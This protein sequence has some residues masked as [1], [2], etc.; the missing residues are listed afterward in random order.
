MGLLVAGAAL[1]MLSRYR[2]RLL[3]AA[4]AL[5]PIV[6]VSLPED[7]QMRFLT[8]LD[9]SVGPANAQESAENRERYFWIALDLWRQ[10]PI[11]GHGPN[12]FRYLSGTGQPA[13]TL[14]GEVLSEVGLLG[15]GALVGLLVGVA[16]NTRE[17]ARSYSG[18]PWSK[19]PFLSWLSIAIC[20]AMTLLLLLGIGGHNLYRF[21]W[22]W[23]GAFLAI[24]VRCVQDGKVWGE[25]DPSVGVEVLDCYDEQ[26]EVELT[27]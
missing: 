26:F 22:L 8:I 18:I 3:L 13:H 17:I 25:D 9:P 12:S 10:S 4:A 23:Y 14:Y 24:A 27:P 16:L 21:T 7:R 1:L 11:V 19:R 20:V 6:W 5:A 2:W 15:A